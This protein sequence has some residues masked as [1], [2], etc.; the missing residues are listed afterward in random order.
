MT[1]DP[2]LDAE[3]LLCRSGR[4]VTRHALSAP[5]FADGTAPKYLQAYDT[6]DSIVNFVREW[7]EKTEIPSRP[8]NW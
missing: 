5:P 1:P 7:S 2:A 8:G 4:N 6:R 3:V